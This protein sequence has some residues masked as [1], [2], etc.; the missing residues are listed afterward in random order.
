MLQSGKKYLVFGVFIGLILAFFY[1][2]YFAP[3]YE[4]KKTGISMI[5]VD[6]WTGQSWRFVDNNWKKIINMDEN[7][8]QIDHTLQEALEI[9]FARVDTGAALNT[10][11]RSYPILKDISDDELLERIKLVYSKLVLTNMYLGDFLKTEKEGTA[12][13]FDKGDMSKE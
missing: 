13:G 7:L 5:K 10:L 4:I 9:P 6:K 8:K 12:K 11:R 1:F 3:R 2:H